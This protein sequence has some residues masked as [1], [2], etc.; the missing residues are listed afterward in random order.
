MRL[1]STDEEKRVSDAISR[2]ERKTSGEIVVV[3][4]E[5]EPEVLGRLQLA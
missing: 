3:T 1:F 5:R 2:A 4:A